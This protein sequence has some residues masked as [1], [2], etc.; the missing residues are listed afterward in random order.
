MKQPLTRK[1]ARTS[2]RV[3]VS[4]G[5]MPS[6]GTFRT[7]ALGTANISTIPRNHPVCASVSLF[8]FRDCPAV[9]SVGNTT[10]VVISSP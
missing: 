7:A 1:P 4:I 9:A 2:A 6:T 8:P 5:F 3:S 10:Q